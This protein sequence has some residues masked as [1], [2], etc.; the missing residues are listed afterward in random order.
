MENAEI[1]AGE[2]A[3]VLSGSTDLALEMEQRDL[4]GGDRSDAGHLRAKEL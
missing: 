4:V 2:V 3:A 1:Y